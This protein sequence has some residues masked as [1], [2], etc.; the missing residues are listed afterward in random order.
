MSLR[1]FHDRLLEKYATLIDALGDPARRVRA[2]LWLAAAYALCWW[3]YAVIAKSSQGI[4]ADMAEMVVWG[5][6]LDWGY[7]KHPPLLGWILAVWFAIFPAQDWAFHLLAALTL[8]SGLALSFLLAGEWLDGEKHAL[9]PFLLALIPFYNF[10]G[11]KFD[12]NSAL[13]PLWAGTAWAFTRSLDT[14]T[15]G[16]AALAGLGAAASMLT[17]YWSGFFILALIAAALFD[18]RRNAYFRSNAPWI[19]TGVGAVLIA[20]HVVWLFKNNFPPLT[21]V[22]TRRTSQSLF[23]ALGSLSEYSFGTLGYCALALIVFAVYVRPSLAGLRESAI[24]PQGDRRRAAIMFWIPLLSPIA[25]AFALKTNLLSLWNTPALALL[26][27]MLMGSPQIRVS[28][29]AAA[30]IAA[31]TVTIAL[32]ALLLSPVIAGV[33]LLMGVENHAAYARGVAARIESEWA[34]TSDKPLTILA[35]PFA[36]ASTTAFYLKDKPSTFADFS[37]YLSPW[38]SDE[39]IARQGAAIVCPAGEAYCGRHLDALVARQRGGRRGEFEVVP[40]WLWLRGAPGRYLIA[41]VPP[42]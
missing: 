22:G 7:P 40:Q 42:R 33:T 20:P 13:I 31:T 11:L 4:N 28:R 26:P 12:Q 14:R 27:V 5:R 17:K 36:L 8:A 25:L 32:G 21:W 19:T 30:R 38:I 24:P 3:L 16:Y 15:P 18:R 1:A 37:R 9:A 2:I 23:D 41:T 34:A 39:T 10:L 6:N 29:D 35:G